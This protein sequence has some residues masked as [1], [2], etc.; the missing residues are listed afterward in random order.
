MKRPAIRHSRARRATAH[1]APAS[2]A[3]VHHVGPDDTHHCETFTAA[4]ALANRLNASYAV[5]VEGAQPGDDGA[6]LARSWA[7]PYTAA[8]WAASHRLSKG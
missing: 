3:V 5:Y 1:P 8:E 7:V 4:V 6:P 2:G